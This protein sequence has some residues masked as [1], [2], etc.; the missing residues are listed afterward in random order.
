MI[1]SKD[2]EKVF[3]KIELPF[4]TKMLNKL[5]I[6]GMYLNIYKPHMKSPQLIPDSK[7]KTGNLFHEYQEQ[8]KEACSCHSY[9]TQSWGV[10]DR[11][12]RQEREMKARKS[13]RKK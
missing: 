1:I 5:G 4:M 7:V 9:F 3:D 13:E 11:E 8:R 2:E 6:G 12:I 10:L